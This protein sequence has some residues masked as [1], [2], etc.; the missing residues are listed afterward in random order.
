MKKNIFKTHFC[1]NIILRNLDY[2]SLELDNKNISY[3]I[4]CIHNAVTNS[5]CHPFL[6][7]YL[8]KTQ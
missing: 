4:P 2:V 1:I 7:M 5:S 8:N 6:K 3:L